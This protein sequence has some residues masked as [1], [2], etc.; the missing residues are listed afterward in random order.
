MPA[1][2]RS[3]LATTTRQYESLVAHAPCCKQRGGFF[4]PE[5]FVSF[6]F[7]IISFV[8]LLGIP[9]GFIYLLAG[10]KKSWDVLWGKSFLLCS[11]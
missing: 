1:S 5:K 2:L 7:F 10:I 11:Y 6:A 8:I 9:L 4:I 3:A